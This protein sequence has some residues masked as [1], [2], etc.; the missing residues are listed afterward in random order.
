MIVIIII[1]MIVIIIIIIIMD[2]YVIFICFPFI[3]TTFLTFNLISDG[4]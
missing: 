4:K 3:F 2:K 1:I